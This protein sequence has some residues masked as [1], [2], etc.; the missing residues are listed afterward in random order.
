[1]ATNIHD[2]NSLEFD[3]ITNNLKNYL[4]NQEE[5]KDYNFEGSN[6]QILIDILSYNTHYNNAY[7]NFGLN[8]SFLESANRRHNILSVS[9]QLGYIPYS[10]RSSQA[11]VDI[12]MKDF[13]KVPD[14]LVLDD[15]VTFTTIIDDVSYNFRIRNSGSMYYGERVK[16][17]GVTNIDRCDMIEQNENGNAYLF[18][19]VELI[20]GV[21]VINY[22]DVKSDN[23]VNFPIM[24]K[25]ADLNTLK[26]TVYPNADIMKQAL[27]DP[28]YINSNIKH[29][30]FSKYN[31]ANTFSYFYRETSNDTF[32]IVF[33]RGFLKK[34][35]IIKMEYNVCSGDSANGALNFVMGNFSHLIS[36]GEEMPL[37][38][39]VRGKTQSNSGHDREPIES[40]REN[41]PKLFAS[42]DRAVSVSDYEALLINRFGYIDAISIWGGEGE[43]D[44]QPGK[45]FLAIKP[46]KNLYLTENQKTEIVKYLKTKSFSSITYEFKDVVFI[47]GIINAKYTYD[48]TLVGRQFTHERL[49]NEIIESIHKFTDRNLKK[50][51]DKLN[52][53]ALTKYVMNERLYLT[54]IDFDVKLTY[55]FDTRVKDITSVYEVDIANPIEQITGGGAIKST[56]FLVYNGSSS[57]RYY[58][59]DDGKGNIKLISDLDMV[60]KK[61]GSIDYE[62]GYIQF[63]DILPIDNKITFTISPDSRNLKNTKNNLILIERDNIFININ[64]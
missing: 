57:N 6:L 61:I 39:I 42:Q 56:P 30:V 21:E 3:T 49:E 51:N 11:N 36:T 34:G 15:K 22:F 48:P 1:M 14:K 64:K 9:G 31:V 10:A 44:P 50:F 62:R 47:K 27:N 46:N 55:D 19:D 54:S 2:Y 60:N 18:R 24:N 38:I 12:I 33:K 45:V 58:I 16:L 8:E 43:I 7:I 59:T 26:I 52:L 13:K 25:M 32:D 53:S 40:I 23:Q 37:N 4:K 35:N 17:D 29:P 20:E 5:F 28:E 63:S 41:A